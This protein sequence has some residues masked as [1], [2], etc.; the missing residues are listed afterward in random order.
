MTTDEDEVRAVYLEL[1]DAW[2]RRDA[3]GFARCFTETGSSIGFDGSAANGRA[4][5]EAHLAPIFRD[6]QTP[7]YVEKLRETRLLAPSVALLRAVAGMV[8]AGAHDINPAL[9][10]VQSVIVSKA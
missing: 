6:H 1:L 7:V 3:A 10:A 4:E 8:P 2:N 5:I 9:N